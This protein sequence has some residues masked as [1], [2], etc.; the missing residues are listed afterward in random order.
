[1]R[2]NMFNFLLFLN[3][4]SYSTKWGNRICEFMSLNSCYCM[5]LS[6][7]VRSVGTQKNSQM[8]QVGDIWGTWTRDLL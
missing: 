8:R 6:N 7:V 3:M 2:A 1:M 5:M 4:E